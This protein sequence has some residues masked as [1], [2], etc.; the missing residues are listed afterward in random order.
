MSSKIARVA[1]I[2]TMVALA[3]S[4]SARAD[5]TLTTSPYNTGITGYPP[6]PLVAGQSE[7]LLT[8]SEDLQSVD[9]AV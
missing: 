2:M 6:P 3:I 8:D 9:T 1:A 4:P 7:V 5:S